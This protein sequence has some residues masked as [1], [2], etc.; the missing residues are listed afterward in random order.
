MRYVLIF[1]FIFY[2]TFNFAQEKNSLLWEISGNGLQ[3]SSYLYGT[4]HVS[5]RIAFRLD[6][7]FYQSLQKSDIVA[8]ESDPDTWLDSDLMTS[9]GYG[10]A[11][12]FKSTG[13]YTFPFAIQNPKKE[14]IASYLSFEDRRVNSILYRTNEYSQNFEE[15][16]YLDMFI[17]QAGKKFSKKVVALE[18]LEESS[19]LVG[20]ASLNAVK[21][22]PDEWLQKKMQESD[23]MTLLQDAYRNRNI[24]MLDSIDRAMYTDHY[25]KHMLTIRNHNMANQ[26]DSLIQ[27]AK[28]FTGIGAA[29]LPGDEGVIELLRNKGYTVKPLTSRSTAKGNTLKEEIENKLLEN[30]YEEVS[31][32][33][34]FFTMKLPNKLYPITEFKNT[35]YISPDLAN[36]SYVM[37][38][39]VNTFAFLKN[40]DVFTLDD[41][42]ELL[43]E[44]IPGKIIEKTKITRNGYQGLDIR[45]QLKNGDHQRYHIFITPL[46]I[47]IFKM[48]GKGDY[49]TQ[50]G[51]TIFNSIHF[52]KSTKRFQKIS[53]GFDDFEIQMPTSYS[54]TNRFRKGDRFVQGYDSITNDYYFLRKV[55]LNDLNFIEEDQFELKQIQKRFY[56]D[57]E[58]ENV[59]YDE[60]K[61]NSLTSKAKMRRGQNKELFLKTTFKRGDYYLMGIVSKDAELAQQYFDSFQLKKTKYQEQF[62]TIR[63]TAMLFHTVTSIKPSKFVENSQNYYT[64]D[65]KPKPYSAYSKKT[66]YQNKNNEAITVEL[67]KS[68]DLLMFENIDSVWALRKKIYARKRFKIHNESNSKRKEGEYELN[69]TLTDTSS[70]RGI[71]IKNVVKNGLLYELKTQIDTISNPSDFISKFYSNFTPYDTLVGS[72]ILADKTDVFFKALRKNDSIVMDGYP[73]IKFQKKHIDSLKYFISEFEYPED[74]KDIQSHLIQQLANLDDP[75]VNSFF[76]QFY[77]KS[78]NNSNAQTKILCAVTKK[79][80]EASTAL[81]LELMSKDLPLVSNT[82]E[83]HQIFKPY[84]DSLP[85]AKKLYPEI[86]D[87]SAIEEYKSPIFSMLAKLQSKGMLKPKSYKKYRKQILN[88]AK[89]QLKRQLGQLTQEYEER[90]FYH[91][92][93]GIDSK[94]L[95]NY[96]ILLYPFVAEKEVRQFFNRLVLVKDPG[97]QTT[98]AALLSKDEMTLPFGKLDSLAADINS[99]L[100]LYSKLKEIGKLNLFPSKYHNE[101]SLAEASLFDYKSYDSQRDSIVFVEQQPLRYKGKSYTGYYFKTKSKQDYDSNFKMHLIVYEKNKPLTTLPFYS[102]AGLRIEDTDTDKE[103]LAYVTEGFLLQNRQ[104]AIVYRPNL[105]GGYGYHGY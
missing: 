95:E 45:N 52:K 48:G 23:P 91:K 38:N 46:E 64:G 11:T 54:F 34:A 101:K 92:A 70:T 82:Y 67:S 105:Y 75:K 65:N 41:L 76:E 85:L 74:K 60:F 57:L 97:V 4:M 18:N 3:H 86:L 35:T 19:A 51:D 61:Q 62:K 93:V 39:R 12:G 17:Y 104:R 53:S 89:I 33:D 13:F 99:R 69:L 98:Y 58:L 14:E 59:E 9:S 26:L 79:S 2:N 42:D 66:V 96:A 8:L 78:Y 90:N 25:R 15:E 55:T 21:K 40:D 72:P 44:N 31:P 27:T 77:V 30:S 10:Q 28:V 103:A 80:D 37:L 68:H 5:K 100:I 83:I 73:F 81:L 6:D 20:R 32:D 63:D 7:V 56:Q 29:H 36:G 102:S 84:L 24:N 43:F 49:V 22:K 47:L 50:F 1:L 88:D 94:I 16:T 87:Y 71:L